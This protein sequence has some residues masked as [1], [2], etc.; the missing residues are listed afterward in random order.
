M[1]IKPLGWIRCLSSNLTFQVALKGSP[2]TWKV[3][4][5]TYS[6]C[7][8]LAPHLVT[9]LFFITLFLLGFFF[10]LL[11][12]IFF[13]C[14]SFDEQK[15][16]WPF[17]PFKLPARGAKRSLVDGL[18]LIHSW[19]ATLVTYPISPPFS[20]STGSITTSVSGQRAMLSSS[21]LFQRIVRANSCKG[22]EEPAQFLKY[23]F[24]ILILT[25]ISK[26]PQ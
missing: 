26:H 2:S 13:H 18:Q 17:L 24:E 9:W 6:C 22:L 12:V 20:P 10:L 21:D 19:I 23:F 25:M 11:Q 1:N 16:F 5:W 8:T 3:K 7:F 14:I 15:C 4:V